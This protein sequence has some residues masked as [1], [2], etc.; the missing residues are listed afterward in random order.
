[1]TATRNV[2][3]YVQDH[4]TRSYIIRISFPSIPDAVRYNSNDKNFLLLDKLIE[5]LEKAKT[6]IGSTQGQ[7]APDLQA[8]IL[9][10]T[11]DLFNYYGPVRGWNA[12][13]TETAVNAL[14]N[15]HNQYID[16]IK[17]NI[18][19]FT[20]CSYNTGVCLT[21]SN[22]EKVWQSTDE[23]Q[24]DPAILEEEPVD[25]GAT[26]SAGAGGVGGQS[27]PP[28][29]TLFPG[30]ASVDPA[31][32]A[33]AADAAEA[34]LREGKPLSDE[35]EL[36]LALPAITSFN[37][38]TTIATITNGVPRRSFGPV[39]K[40]DSSFKS[41]NEL[42]NLLTVSSGQMALFYLKQKTFSAF[43]PSIEIAKVLLDPETRKPKSIVRLDFPRSVSRD[44]NTLVRSGGFS[45]TKSYSS[46]SY[47]T[48]FKRNQIGI[49]SFT[50][51]LDN[52]NQET[53]GRFVSAEL[54]IV[55]DSVDALF[56][57][58]NSFNNTF[59]LVDPGQSP[60][61]RSTSYRIS[62]ILIQPDCLNSVGGIPT[63]I[64]APS[65]DPNAYWSS[66]V[67]GTPWLPECYELMVTV[68]N[69]TDPKVLKG[70]TY[71]EGD[72]GEDLKYLSMA[73][74][75]DGQTITEKDFDGF[76]T[77]L[78][79]T[80]FKHDFSFEENG[81]VVV[82]ASYNGRME[83]KLNDSGLTVNIPA[84]DDAVDLKVGT[85]IGDQYF[86]YSGKI[87]T[88][89]KNPSFVGLVNNN[90]TLKSLADKYNFVGVTGQYSGGNTD[91]KNIKSKYIFLETCL[92][93]IRESKNKIT[94]PT[95]NTFIKDLDKTLKEFK[96]KY[97]NA[98]Y[99]AVKQSLINN[100]LTYFYSY[101]NVRTELSGNSFSFA[102]SSTTDVI[103]SINQTINTNHNSIYGGDTI[104]G[105][106]P[107]LRHTYY[108]DSEKS[109][110]M[111]LGD[112]VVNDVSSERMPYIGRG[113]SGSAGVVQ[114]YILSDLMDAM[115][116]RA[117]SPPFES[118]G[119]MKLVLGS[120]AMPNLS[121]RPGYIYADLGDLPVPA[122]M[123]DEFVTNQT[124]TEKPIYTFNSMFN[125]FLNQVV[126]N[127]LNPSCKLER[128]PYYYN[129][130]TYYL[131][132]Y[133][134]NSADLLSN[135]TTVD[136]KMSDLFERKGTMTQDMHGRSKGK[137]LDIIFYSVQG[138]VNH[139][140]LSS[141]DIGK[142]FDNKI[143]HLR[144]NGTFGIFKS[145]SFSKDDMPYAPEARAVSAGGLSNVGQFTGLYKATI[146]AVGNNLLKN[147][148]LIYIDATS[149]GRELG[150][151]TDSRSLSWLMGM[152]GLYI[153]I[154]TD[155]N[156]TNSNYTTTYEARFVSRPTKSSPG[157]GINVFGEP[158]ETPRELDFS[159][160]S[161]G[162][163]SGQ[164]TTN[165]FLQ[166]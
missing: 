66:P 52:T 155:H 65:I 71:T 151:P 128:L 27:A 38:K 26:T 127:I 29:P 129:T 8:Q 37:R 134:I 131:S 130:K 150:N 120:F 76:K 104:F 123:F 159:S 102:S 6:D 9:N 141:G 163:T 116:K 19:F 17:E 112:T 160:F 110:F 154:K 146:Q 21:E 69:Y 162:A 11:E 166:K 63:S 85:E 39:I 78:Y 16:F 28:P 148:D 91:N 74:I 45:D 126:K 135:D 83:S 158:N 13:S 55:M 133:N 1:M 50:W 98:Y 82:K 90:L 23:T 34:A 96:D 143:P 165:A 121:N 106:A 164:S 89:L 40:R 2:N 86:L 105:G 138:I 72:V 30:G 81:K 3:T 118:F 51:R 77:T 142:D 67:T 24:A 139:S 122:K 132:L 46:T 32:A 144:Y 88:I 137:P 107:T 117:S 36:F 157:S 20:D 35:C 109:S 101:G 64:T 103:D 145:V 149:L 58:R 111:S 136:V 113:T 57:A 79:L 60:N 15:V 73:N 115:I 140:T 48:L 10:V 94:D 161:D 61:L 70:L 22:Y 84:Q 59:D 156:L 95:V 43:I 33:A 147:G 100:K 114:Y 31:A 119:G 92:N 18:N 25:S 87:E 56:A 53:S 42:N 62:D 44:D 97:Y 5:D 108:Y 41:K 75:T 99:K 12:N 68:G 124:K 47:D 125:D 80:L 153:I 14:S 49:K 4:Y 152:G 93:I 7:N 54:E